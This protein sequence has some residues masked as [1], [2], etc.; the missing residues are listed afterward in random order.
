M[1]T[2]TEREKE[3]IVDQAI[4]HHTDL[5]GYVRLLLRQAYT[6]ERTINSK[7]DK[8]LFVARDRG[9]PRKRAL[10]TVSN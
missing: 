1:L 3:Y 4:Q 5:S 2:I 10:T 9:R 6:T 7:S 8:H